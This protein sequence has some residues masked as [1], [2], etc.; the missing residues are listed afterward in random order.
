MIRALLVSFAIIA[1]T[2]AARADQIPGP[3]GSEVSVYTPPGW[4]RDGGAQGSQALLLA[5]SPGKDAALF[6]AVV[7]AKNIAAAMQLIDGLLGKIITGAKVEQGGKLTVNG[8]AAVAFTGSGK[9][10]EGGKP[11]SLAAVILQPNATHVLFAIAMAHNDVMPKYKAEF[12]KA[13]AG[14]KKQ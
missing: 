5:V 4:A 7:E 10:V 8:M 2:A 3:P 13:L 12:D 9:A 14:I 6:Y 1:T 11:S